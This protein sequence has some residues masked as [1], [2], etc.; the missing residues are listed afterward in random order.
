[1]INKTTQSSYL[2]HYNSGDLN[3]MV[4]TKQNQFSLSV[5]EQT[6]PYI[7]N[8]VTN[9]VDRTVT[10]SAQLTSLKEALASDRL[11][12]SEFSETITK[13]LIP[14]AQG[15]V[16][17]EELQYA[18]IT[19]LLEQLDPELASA[20]SSG[21]EQLLSA[22]ASPLF[23]DIAKLTLKEMVDSGLLELDTA[24]WINAASFSSAQLDSNLTALY[25]NRGSSSDA[26]IAVASLGSAIESSFSNLSEI[27]SGQVPL[28][29]LSLDAP[30]NLPLNTAKISDSQTSSS[31]FLWKPSSERDGKLVV[32]LPA[33]LSG[34]IAAAE[35]HSAVPP[36]EL[37]LLEH[38]RFTGDYQNGGRAHFRFQKPGEKYPDGSAIVVTL[39]NGEQVIFQINNS[40]QR[41]SL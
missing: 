17:E 23:E 28:A 7:K 4:T 27:T 21:F 29:A 24:E 36:S 3:K 41:N 34:Q 1:M 2:E 8:E 33:D 9:S 22:N 11:N 5:N 18:I 37:T 30:S 20:F 10:S 39:N 26:T 19:H 13:T 6:V 32:L 31:G 14:D 40:S 25:D 12:N 15:N 35:L 16:H 38:G